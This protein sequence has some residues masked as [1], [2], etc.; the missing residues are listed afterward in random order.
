MHANRLQL[1]FLGFLAV[2]AGIVL[3]LAYWQ[4]IRG[5]ELRVEARDQYLSSKVLSPKRGQILTQKAYPLV[6]NEPIYNLTVYTPHLE[7]TPQEIA[8]LVVPHLEFDLDTPEYATQPAKQA[9][10]LEELRALE[11][12]TIIDRTNS[13]SY[14]VLAR[15]LSLE[16]KKTL[17]QLGILGLDFE[18]GYTRSYPEASMAAHLVGFVGRNDLGEPTGY[19]GLEGYYDRELRGKAGLTKEEQDASGN[20]LIFGDFLSLSEREGRN[21]RLHLER[22]V[23]FQV[24][25][26]LKTG[27]ALY[28]ASAG[29][30]LVMEPNTGAILALASFPNYDPSKFFKFDTALYK[31]PAIASS[32]EPGSTFKVLTMAA[33][34]NEGAV[35]LS[36]RCDICAGPLPIDK[37]TIKTWNNEYNPNSTPEEIL[38]NSDNIGMVWIER[39]LGGDKFLEYIKNFGFGEKT[40][41]DLQEEATPAL[42]S[43]W[44][45]VDFATASFGQGIAVTSIQMLRAVA[46]IANGGNLMEPHVVA[47]VTGEREIPIHPKVVRRVISETTA[48]TITKLM[49]ASAEHGDAKWTRLP[50]YTVAGKTGTAQIAVQGHYD[51]EKT[52]AS[53]VG[54]APVKDPKFVMLVKL[55]E[56]TSSPWGSETAAPLWFTIARQLLL[57]YNVPPDSSN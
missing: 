32:Y 46:A 23:Q 20:P 26:A 29:E 4:L 19:F 50:D 57:H 37:Y 41:I 28:G 40:G 45:E 18:E 36:D 17:S 52:I 30:V 39:K 14:A 22:S 13:Q 34:F 43:R 10:R 44:G 9:T 54:F 1:F 3:R 15:S 31:N 12:S 38:A 6:V 8:D 16:Q 33:A 21:L 2:T 49:I 55:R 53:F 11:R 27:L 42:R 35:N 7:K 51:E 5:G 56:P 47:S 25:E 24:E 48:S